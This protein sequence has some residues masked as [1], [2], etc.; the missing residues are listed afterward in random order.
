MNAGMDKNAK[1]LSDRLFV[2]L[3]TY[4]E[5]RRMRRQEFRTR[6]RER[7]Q[8]LGDRCQRAYDDAARPGGQEQTE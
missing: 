2:D 4:E 1:T 6:L 8:E 7:L 3:G 5:L